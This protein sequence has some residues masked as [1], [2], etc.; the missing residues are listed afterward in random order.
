MGTRRLIVLLALLAG[1]A[2][3][4]DD[5]RVLRFDPPLV[6]SEESPGEEFI[7]P[8]DAF[9][10]AS[11][12][13]ALTGETSGQG[14]AMGVG[15]FVVDSVT[16]S[17]GPARS[18][19][20]Y[21]THVVEGL[22]HVHPGDRMAFTERATTLDER[23]AFW[24]D[25][26]P[27]PYPSLIVGK[28]Y[29]I[30]AR[31]SGVPMDEAVVRQLGVPDAVASTGFSRIVLSDLR[32]IRDILPDLREL[33]AILLRPAS[34]GAAPLRKF[35]LERLDTQSQ[36]LRW[37]VAAELTYNQ[38]PYRGMSL[39]EAQRVANYSETI[40]QYHRF[41]ILKNL[42]RLTP[43]PMDHWYLRAFSKGAK[44]K[45]DT[46]NIGA[47]A[48]FDDTL[49]DVADRLSIDSFWPMLERPTKQISMWVHAFA[50]KRDPRLLPIIL[51][52]LDPSRLDASAPD[53]LAHYR[54]VPAAEEAVVRAATDAKVK[55]DKR[56]RALARESLRRIGTPRAQ[57]VAAE[58]ADGE[59]K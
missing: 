30:I 4:A 56:A 46:T 11:Y 42:T 35:L 34:E 31:G 50:K 6:E 54:G 43:H 38:A 15:L 51:R 16:T 25:M 41:D 18:L 12:R 24:R 57:A 17:P 5:P 7:R 2:Q 28:E 10:F 58:L 44:G 27:W 3:A 45:I 8:D 13:D 33:T 26:S 9:H 29:F 47:V 19:N 14:P 23:R 52:H 59:E 49:Q 53:A 22:A 21:R 48:T 32:R 55:S 1:V 37:L 39:A 20:V 36:F 40:N